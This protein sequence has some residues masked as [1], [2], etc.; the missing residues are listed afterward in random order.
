MNRRLTV[1]VVD[2]GPGGRLVG[3]RLEID[4]TQT[5]E[6][7]HVCRLAEL[8]LQDLPTGEETP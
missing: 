4:T 7:R 6:W 5:A 3:R 1:V 8:F 2:T